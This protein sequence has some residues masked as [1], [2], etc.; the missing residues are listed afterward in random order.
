MHE[1][2]GLLLAAGVVVHLTM[3]WPWIA[4]HARRF[5]DRLPLRARLNALLNTCLFVCMTSATASCIVIS[6][7][8]LPRP[9]PQPAEYLKWHHIHD[10][11]ATALMFLVGLHLALNW[12]LISKAVRQ[13]VTRRG[14][15]A[16]PVA[17]RVAPP[18]ASGDPRPFAWVRSVA[19]RMAMIAVAV[20]GVAAV[21]FALERVLPEPEVIFY[22][23]D[24]R[25]ERV[26]APPDIAQLR[27]DQRTPSSRALPPLAIKAIMI[28]AT[29]FVG[30]KVLRVRL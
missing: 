23:P 13:I 7:Y 9:D 29:A 16:E 30:R 18:R 1:L 5:F 6:K 17:D 25:V 3:Q 22:G 28:C 24:G 20:C 15:S 11:S 19:L 4:A 8:V 2:L 27:P 21:S 10:I 14:A 12:D 26:A